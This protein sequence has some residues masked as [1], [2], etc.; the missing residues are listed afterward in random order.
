VKNSFASLINIRVLTGMNLRR[1][2]FD[3]DSRRAPEL[4]LFIGQEDDRGGPALPSLA[5][6][7][8]HPFLSKWSSS[9]D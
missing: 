6:A 8:W 9:E 7:S 2:G 4:R 1:G 3:A 5:K